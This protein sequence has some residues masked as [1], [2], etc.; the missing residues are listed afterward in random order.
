MSVTADIASKLG[1]TTTAENGEVKV[2]CPF[3]QDD[4][5][6]LSFNLETGQWY[7]HACKKGGTAEQLIEALGGAAKFID[8]VIVQAHHDLLLSRPQDLQ[9]ILEK[10]MWS[11]DTI[12]KFNIGF[13]L[14]RFWIPVPDTAGNWINVRKYD[15]RGRAESKMIPYSPGWGAPVLFPEWA[16]KNDGIVWVFEGEPDTIL[17]HQ[18]GLTCAITTTGGA[19]TWKPAFTKALV[20]R[21]VAF[22]Y[23]VDDPGKGA[24]RDHAR[25]LVNIAKSVRVVVLPLEGT[26]KEK[27]F[28]DYIVKKGG[29]L[30]GMHALYAQAEEVK[31]ATSTARIDLPSEVLD[32]AVGEFSHESYANKRVRFKGVVVGKDLAPYTVPKRVSAQCD[33]GIAKCAVCGIAAGVTEV[34]F[35]EATRATISLPNST[36]REMAAIVERAFM[37]P[38]CDR[39]RF[40]VEEHQTI[41]IFHVVPEITGDARNGQEYVVREVYALRHGVK[42]NK[43]HVIE[44]VALPDPKT[45]RATVLAYRVE[46]TGGALDSFQLTP[47]LKE[48]LEIFRPVAFNEESAACLALGIETGNPV[49]VK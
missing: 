17:A 46:E 34:V 30:D 32:V 36:D 6:S 15:A 48:L 45:Q 42:T 40:T 38:R 27:D 28:T 14:D 24:S 7:C 43:P 29:T 22:C 44:G 3:H 16:L 13:D 23:D 35:D 12:K 10:R 1:L 49:P 47:N 25:R 33:M 2:S 26:K 20:G 31:S 39:P 8:P 19:S 37:V 9:F 41:E 18:V 4:K 5:P 21:D 11:L